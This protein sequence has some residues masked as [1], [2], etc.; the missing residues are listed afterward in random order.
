MRSK[1]AGQAV[2]LDTGIRGV[3]RGAC[4]R[5]YENSVTGFGEPTSHEAR[6]SGDAA[7]IEGI[8]TRNYVPGYRDPSPEMPVV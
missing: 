3:A 7:A 2:H 1:V 5:P 6:V 8:L 4:G